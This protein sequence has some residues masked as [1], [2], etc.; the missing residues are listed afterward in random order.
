MSNAFPFPH[1]PSKH[2]PIPSPLSLLTNPTTPTSWLWHSPTLGHQAF[3]AL[4]ASPTDEQQ[5]HH[6]LHM[7]LEPGVLFGWCFS[8]RELWLVHIVVPPMGLQTPSVPWILTLV[9]LL[10]TL[11]SVQWLAE[12]IH[13]FICQALVELLRRQLYQASVSKHLLASKIVSGFGDCIW[14]GS[15]WGAVSGW[16]FHQSLLYTL[17]L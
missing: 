7:H 11:C 5:G 9:P 6:L 4:R 13:L 8:P 17:S 3:T 12:S 15:P 10:V 1:L 2:T 16:P 14:D